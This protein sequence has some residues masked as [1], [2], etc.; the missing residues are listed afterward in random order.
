MT[1][2]KLLLVA[3]VAASILM[4]AIAGAATAEVDPR[5][6]PYYTHGPRYWKGDTEMIWQPGA[7]GMWGHRWIHGIYIEGQHRKPDA[8]RKTEQPAA[9]RR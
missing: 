8:N 1:K 9:P 6:K 7:V 2:N 4:P 3:I 5:D